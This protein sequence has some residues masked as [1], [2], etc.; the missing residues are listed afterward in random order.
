[1]IIILPSFGFICF[2]TTSLTL[3]LTLACLIIIVI[4]VANF[5]CKMSLILFILALLSITI[6][7]GLISFFKFGYTK[8]ILS[9]IPLTLMV[10]SAYLMSV[11]MNKIGFA[12]TKFI[13]LTIFNIL[14][15]FG[16][17]SIFYRFPYCNYHL[18]V[19]PVFPFSEPSHFALALNIFILPIVL[20]SGFKTS[21][22]VLFNS[23]LLSLLLPSLTLLFSSALAFL[24]FVRKYLSTG[25]TFLSLPL[26]F[27]ILSLLLFNIPH[28][29]ERISPLFDLINIYDVDNTF[30][31]S[32][33]V[34][35]QGWEFILLNMNKNYG[36]GLGFQMLGSSETELGYYSYILEKISLKIPNL[37]NG[38]FIASKLIS[39]FGIIGLLLTVYYIIWFIK[40]FLFLEKNPKILLYKG[41][42]AGFV[43]D[44]F[45][46]GLGYFNPQVFFFLLA[47]FVLYLS[48]RIKFL[49]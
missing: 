18:L 48:K 31:L 2:Q 34:Y 46:R 1:M 26:I 23:F 37:E 40:F 27:Y 14:L 29:K 39:E 12:S 44:L 10:L 20:I 5:K 11:E 33:I 24:F 16:W 3:G 43:I 30:N 8:S 41:I 22:Y 4:N 15:I 17:L 49:V 6:S 36:L 42:I 47:I 19:K 25:Q 9:V 13:F 35:L 32:A 45:I 7:Y 21:L 38:S 28:Y